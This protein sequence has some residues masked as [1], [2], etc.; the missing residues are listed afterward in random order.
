M[1]DLPSLPID[2]MGIRYG[3]SKLFQILVPLTSYMVLRDLLLK[4]LVL[5]EKF[6]EKF[7]QI[8]PDNSF[9]NQF[10]TD[11]PKI[12]DQTVGF[13]SW[14]VGCD[15]GFFLI[16]TGMGPWERAFTWS[17]LLPYTIAQYFVYFLIGRRMLVDGQ[18]NPFSQSPSNPVTPKPRPWWKQILS[19]YLHE[20]LNVTNEYVPLRQVFLKPFVDYGGLVLSWSLYNVGI[21]FFQSGEMNFAPVIQFAFF[22]MLTF[23]LVN[24][25]GFIIGYNIGEGI[26]AAISALEERFSRWKRQQISVV[27]DSS[28]ESQSLSVRLYRLSESLK[29][30]WQNIKYGYLWQ[31]QTF[32]GQYGIGRKWLLTTVSGVFAVIIIAPSVSDVM[33]S[34]GNNMSDLWFDRMG[35]VDQVQVAQIE[36]SVSDQ[37][38]LPNS[39]VVI[40]RFPEFWQALYTPE[41][42]F[43]NIALDDAP[44]SV[45]ESEADTNI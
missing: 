14:K 22:Q 11:L 43:E 17:G 28:Q 12:F 34:V 19:K 41:T 5:K 45:K 30:A 25:Y 38:N 2:P 32:L 37:L 15:L 7:N 10:R 36:P 44:S 40:S 42:Q 21:F 29:L 26:D 31:L 27:N 23:Y 9:F 39:E 6:I 1:I 4:K 24:T 18:L 33:F 20:D 3:S 13:L 8:L 16:V 35:E